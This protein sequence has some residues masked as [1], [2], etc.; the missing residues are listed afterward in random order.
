MTSSRRPSTSNASSPGSPGVGGQH[1]DAVVLVAE[2]ELA[3]RADH[4]GGDVAVGLA[5]ARSR[6]RP[7]ARRRAAP[8]RRGRRPRSCGRRRRCPAARRCRWRRR[9][10]LAPADGL[11]VLLRLGL[12][13]E[14]AAEHQRAGDV[15]AGGAASA[16]SLRP[17]TV[18]RSA[19]SLGV[20]VGRQVDVLAEPGDG[21]AHQIS[22]PKAEVKRTSPS[23]TSRRSSTP[24]RNISVRSMPM[25]K[26]KPV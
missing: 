18:S 6:S 2:A 1:D 14:H 10:R 24:W 3:G 21:G 9:R 8:R 19:S 7:A 23:K 4:P 25:P 5:R 26:A 16:S 13:G 22:V 11:A 12:E 20:E 15:G 17:S